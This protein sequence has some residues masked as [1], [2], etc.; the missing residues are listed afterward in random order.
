MSVAEEAVQILAARNRPSTHPGAITD[1]HAMAE[2]LN[3]IAQFLEHPEDY[4]TSEVR[5]AYTSPPRIRYERD[6]SMFAPAYRTV[7]VRI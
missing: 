3:S 1:P 5:I 4:H 6:P 7:T 2:V